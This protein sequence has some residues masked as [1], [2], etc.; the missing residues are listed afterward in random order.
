MDASF[1]PTNGGVNP[2]LTIAAN[3]LRVVAI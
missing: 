1:M 2:G 3:A